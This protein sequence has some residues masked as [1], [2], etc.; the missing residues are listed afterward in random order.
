[1]YERNA[2]V[3]ERYFNQMFGYNMKNNI[4]TNF[5]DYCEL[6]DCLERYHNISEEEENVIQEY[7]SIANKIREIQKI[8]E[9]L[10]RKNSRL[11]EERATIVQNVGENAE[12]IQRK[13][14]I[15]NGSIQELNNEIQ[16]N[17]QK[18][19]DVVAEFNDK[20]LTRTECGRNRRN[21]ESEYNKKLNN[22]L[23]NYQDIDIEIEKVAKSFIEIETDE[24]EKEIKEKI[25]KNGEKE[26]TPFN[27]EV[28]SKAISLSID[29]QKRETDILANIYDKTNRLFT[30]IKN[31][32]VR[33]DKHKKI[34][35][36]A[37]CK[38]EFI[39]AI[40]EYLVQFLDNERLTAVNGEEEHT[41]LMTEACKNLDDDL[42][43]INNLYTLLLKEATKK[44]SKK[45]Y[46]ELYNY[47]YLQE[48]EEKSEKFDVEI[49]K[50]NL[51]VTII[52]PNH[53]RNDGMQKIYST[54]IKC[55]TEVYDRD[56][57]EFMPHTIEEDSVD[58]F[59]DN[60]FDS[61]NDDFGQENTDEIN[62]DYG[63]I[64]DEDEKDSKAEIDKKID[65][66]LGF[67]DIKKDDEEDDDWD[68]DEDD[69]EDDEDDDLIFG[70]EDN[71]NDDEENVDHDD[72]SWN[73]DD[74]LIIS[75]NDDDDDDLIFDDKD[76]NDD[77]DDNWDD[78]DWDDTKDENNNTNEDENEEDDGEVNLDIWGNAIKSKKT[79]NYDDDKDTDDEEDDNWDDDDLI[80]GNRND[81]ED[82]DEEDDYN[83]DWDEEEDDDDDDWD[84]ESSNKKAKIGKHSK[85]YSRN[86]KPNNKKKNRSKEI[87]ETEEETSEDWANQFIDIDK[88]GKSKKKKGFFNK[89]KK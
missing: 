74:D 19:V 64:Q 84:D 42:V 20:S 4:K 77:E 7:D 59:E 49:K 73:D 80:F 8:Q 27:K 12:N 17:A 39:G 16:L 25:E 53:W 3:L 54:F 82:D 89:F 58:D 62:L 56:L 88:K 78:D 55:V 51:P 68:D 72:D 86:K 11:Q 21:V 69:E 45:S 48:L 50:L 29:I 30:E 36:D 31:N 66:I 22:T 32:A 61:F 6:V 83:D 35:R 26:K 40:K 28:L 52:N 65:M 23:D 5:E 33:I 57:S 18:F 38:L 87:E 24:I 76:D 85:D 37:N 81:E 14:D 46:P 44:I 34:I 67:N 2:V 43:Q 9:S 63:E 41:K 47:D 10:N 70:N 15:V 75:N 1:M 71:G 60:E 13:L 79:E